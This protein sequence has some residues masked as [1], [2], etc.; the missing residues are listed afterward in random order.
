VAIAAESKAAAAETD[1]IA[2]KLILK[3]LFW[4]DLAVVVD[5]VMTSIC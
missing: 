4:D 1:N 5:M 2:A 3:N